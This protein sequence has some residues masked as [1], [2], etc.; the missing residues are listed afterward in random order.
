VLTLFDSLCYSEGTF[1]GFF[2]VFHRICSFV[3]PERDCNLKTNVK[4]R[5]VT[6]ANILSSPNN[7]LLEPVFAQ[8]LPSFLVQKRKE[9][10]DDP[11]YSESERNHAAPS[12]CENQRKSVKVKAVPEGGPG[13]A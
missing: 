3:L 2:E 10:E 9:E 1:C 5:P 13:W 4:F 12:E 11:A 6:S 8:N 7:G